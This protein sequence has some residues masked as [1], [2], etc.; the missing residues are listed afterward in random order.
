LT[1]WNASIAAAIPAGNCSVTRPSLQRQSLVIAASLTI[2]DV[3]HCHAVAPTGVKDLH[4]HGMV[5]AVVLVTSVTF[6]DCAASGQEGHLCSCGQVSVAE[7]DWGQAHHYQQLSGRPF[8]FV[9]A[10]DCIY[11][12]H[13]V[14]ALYR[15]VLALTNERSISKSEDDWNG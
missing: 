12:E 8:D 11:H 3:M 9:L 4:Q 1:A 10:A 13:L 5:I 14:R 2:I 15:T 6:C 7:L